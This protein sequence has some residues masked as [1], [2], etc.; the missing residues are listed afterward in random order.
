[1]HETSLD[2]ET[3]SS[4]TVIDWYNYCPEVCADR[5][6]KHHTV[7]IG[8]PG[9]TVEIDQSKF[10]KRK[11]HRGH[12]IEG[13]WAFRGNCRETKAC[14]L[15]PWGVKRSMPRTGTSKDLFDSYLQ[16]WL[17]RQRY[18]SDPFGNIT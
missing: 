14:C 17:W 12:F 5:I 10:C 18:K 1:M 2:D 9:S 8:G 7:P 11:Y 15:V 4:E 6:M 13:Q 16:E 3:T